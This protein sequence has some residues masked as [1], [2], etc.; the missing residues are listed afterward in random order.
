[1]KLSMSHIVQKE[2]IYTAMHGLEMCTF[3]HNA[4]FNA[5]VMEKKSTNLYF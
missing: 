4:Y 5:S 2:E 3:G 1:M